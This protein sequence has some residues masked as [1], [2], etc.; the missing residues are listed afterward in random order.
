MRREVWEAA[1]KLYTDAANTIESL[2][3]ALAALAQDR[4]RQLREAWEDGFD[5]G[6]DPAWLAKHYG[7]GPDRSDDWPA[8]RVKGWL[9]FCSTHAAAPEGGAKE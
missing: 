4:D 8:W 7:Y 1:A 6:G 9:D 5:A 3:A 2:R